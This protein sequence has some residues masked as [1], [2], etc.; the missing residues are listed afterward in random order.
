MGLAVRSLEPL[1]NGGLHGMN[2]MLITGGESR[3]PEE[4]SREE[5]ADWLAWLAGWNGVA[6]APSGDLLSCLRSGLPSLYLQTAK[7]QTTLSRPAP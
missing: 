4:L 5:A 7:P 2:E 6:N 3:S 1:G